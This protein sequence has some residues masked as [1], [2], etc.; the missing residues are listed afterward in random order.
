MSDCPSRYLTADGRVLRCTVPGDHDDDDM[1]IDLNGQHNSNTRGRSWMNYD[2]VTWPTNDPCAFD[3]TCKTCRG[4]G[5]AEDDR[6]VGSMGA[7]DK[8]RCWDCEGAGVDK[9]I[10]EELARKMWHALMTMFPTHP[11][12]NKDTP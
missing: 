9:T 10:P 11:I 6:S 5:R 2:G 8:V 3:A 1:L 4:A 7:G 12:N